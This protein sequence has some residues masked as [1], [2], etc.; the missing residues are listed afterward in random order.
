MPFFFILTS[1][2]TIFSFCQTTQPN[3]FPSTTDSKFQP[4]S[5]SGLLWEVSGNGLS[6][7]SFVYGT[8]H[9][10]AAKDYF[11]PEGTLTAIDQSKKVVFEINMNE[12]NDI[13]ALMPLMSKAFM[14]NGKTLKDVMS[15]EDY[16]LVTE[17]F[18][19]LGLPMM[20]L[21]RIKPMFLTVFASGDFNPGDLQT[22]KIKSYEMEFAEIAANSNKP[23][24][25]LETVEYQIAIFDKIPDE[26]QAEMLIEA[27]K[28]SDTDGDQFQ[29]MAALYKAQDIEKMY[30]MMKGDETISNYE[31]ELLTTRNKNWIPVME[32]M[33]R[34]QPTFF[35]VG[36]GHLG[37]PNGV[38]QLLQKRGYHLKPYRS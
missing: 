30:E 19:Q 24:G 12:M 15:G 20:F 28:S 8:I 16:E 31:D 29:E 6:K 5:N 34:T 21:E 14:S 33:M 10:I 17:H 38:I 11:L 26:D 25:G 1:L 32:E 9:L 2:L 27:I 4:L 23:I 3:K 22:G 18:D 36:A 13:A 7:P 37:G 35:A